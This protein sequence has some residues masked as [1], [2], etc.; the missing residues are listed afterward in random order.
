MLTDIASAF[1]QS[2]ASS[3]GSSSEELTILR[4]RL[5][6]TLND[7]DDIMRSKRSARSRQPS[8]I[9]QTL[10]NFARNYGSGQSD[11]SFASASS[12]SNRTFTYSPITDV[13]TNPLYRPSDMARGA[14]WVVSKYYGVPASAT[15]VAMSV[16]GTLTDVAIRRF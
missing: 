14:V 16:A 8:S 5:S 13:I 9:F 1:S 3:Y 12:D 2:R 4:S 7:L 15:S 6:R 10:S 11:R